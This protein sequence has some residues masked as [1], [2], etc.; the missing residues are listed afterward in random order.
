M[1]NFFLL[2]LSAVFAVSA[3]SVFGQGNSGY[4]DNFIQNGVLKRVGFSKLKMGEQ[5][6]SFTEANRFIADP[7]MARKLR[8]GLILEKVAI[9]L[10][11]EVW[12]RSAGHGCCLN[13]VREG[14]WVLPWFQ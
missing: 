12:L 3:S 8:I 4:S 5:R 14:I 1:K 11:P 2:A 6:F 13:S 9:G 7:E 10:G